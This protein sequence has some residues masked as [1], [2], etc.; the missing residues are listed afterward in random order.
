MY[1][2]KEEVV[3]AENDALLKRRDKRRLRERASGGDGLPASGIHLR[4]A[5][6]SEVVLP[7]ANFSQVRRDAGI[8][9]I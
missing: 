7:S 6:R 5:Q 8:A 1:Q 3:G 2:R 9:E 4:G